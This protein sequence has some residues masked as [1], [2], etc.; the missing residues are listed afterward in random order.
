MAGADN[1][2]GVSKGR[3]P[4]AGVRVLAL[5]Q[6]V[7]APLC[8]QHLADLGAEVVKIERPGSGDFAR[9]YDTAVAGESAWFYWLNRGKR[10]LALDIKHPGAAEILTRLLV[11]SDVFIQNLAP[12]AADRIGLSGP[13]LRQRYPR[14]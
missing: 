2:A 12:G 1:A 4:L 14:L 11:R 7:A 13:T 5:E 8:T 10:S 3:P 6:A 9:S